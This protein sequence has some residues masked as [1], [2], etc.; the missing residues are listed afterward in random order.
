MAPLKHSSTLHAGDKGPSRAHLLT[1]S[2]RARGRW[3]DTRP[4]RA[5]SSLV[6]LT[7]ARHWRANWKIGP[8]RA[9]PR[10]GG[11]SLSVHDFRSL[12]MTLI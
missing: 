4:L 5:K 7:E 6:G 12:M 3:T 11:L 2:W 9:A 10:K 8:A 1:A